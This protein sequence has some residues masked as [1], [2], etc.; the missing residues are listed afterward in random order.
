MAEADHQDD[1]ETL[2]HSDDYRYLMLRVVSQ[3][4]LFGPVR[5]RKLPVHSASAVAAIPGAL[6]VVDDDEGIYRVARGQATLW[7][8]REHHPELGDLEGLAVDDAHTVVWALAEGSGAV[9]ALRLAPRSP[10][11]EVVGHLP[12]PGNRKNKGFEGLAFMP[13]RL[14]P[15]RRDSL[16]A[17][18]ESQPRRVLIF[19]LP[20]LALTHEL[21]LPKEGKA[22]LDDL[23]DV[24]IDPKTGALLLLSDQSRRIVIATLVEQD[25]IVSGHYD[26]PLQRGEKP[27]GIDFASPTRLLVV[28][29][30]SS[31]LLEIAV[32]RE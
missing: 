18:N 5:V 6:L 4:L 24:T 17:V 2:A 8:G 32:R 7:A 9:I 31:K 28:T 19:R 11:P 29:D 3:S 16:V 14:S 12:R 27:E 25:L 26:L 22:L 1:C 30:D 13:A 10:Q 15:T 20:E 21:K 23:A